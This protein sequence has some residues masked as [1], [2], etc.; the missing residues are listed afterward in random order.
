MIFS[1]HHLMRL[2]VFLCMLLFFVTL[3][4]AQKAQRIAYI[5]MEFILNNVPE[6][7]EAQNTLDAKVTKWRS[8]LDKLTRHIEK[9]KTDLTNERAILT[10][11]LIQEKEDEITLKQQEFRRLES[12]YFGP[13][14]DMFL[15]RKQLVKPVQDQVYNSIQDIA[16]R[17]KYD[18]VFDKSSDLVMLYS[19]KKYDISSLVLRSIV[20]DQKIQKNKDKRAKNSA[21][22]KEL[23]E[24]QKKALADKEAANKK[25]QADRLAKKKKIDD[26]RKKRL[27]D[28]EAKRKLLKENKKKKEGTKKEQDNN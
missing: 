6:Y 13:N 20:R 1:K 24:K 12:L 22:K 28:I 27:A 7:L 25:K 17:Q 23:T 4:E 3:A 11:D 5:D 2:K 10:Q 16:T 19:N 21:P 15:L 18:F 26:A 14:G 9:L 8:E